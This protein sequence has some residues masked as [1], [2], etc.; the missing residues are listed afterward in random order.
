MELTDVGAALATDAASPLLVSGFGLIIV[1]FAFKI[2]AAPFHMWVADVYEGAPT[3]STAYMSVTVKAAGVGALTRILLTAAP[4]RSDLWADLLWWMAVITMVL[5]NLLALQQTSVKRMLAFSSV[6]H[7]GYALIALAACRGVDGSFD[8][9]VA[10][11]GV[12]YLLTYTFMTLG[13]FYVLVYL[14]HEVKRADGSL[15]WQD[16]ETFDDLSGAAERHPW[17]AFAMTVF[18]ISLG[19]FPPTA[20]FVGKFAVF[21]GAVAQGHVVLVLIGVFASLIS[22]YY[23]LRVVVAM[24]MTSTMLGDERPDRS[25]GAV[26]ALAVAG[27]LMLGILPSMWIGWAMRSVFTLA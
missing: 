1:G 16:A 25:I 13:A 3:T 26:V 22:L 7:T 5:G 9:D 14:G 2:G 8:P 20:G 23:Y 24:Y 27:T 10:G 21:S 17:A 19:G 6:A 15:E 12:F 4:T 11:A 18:V